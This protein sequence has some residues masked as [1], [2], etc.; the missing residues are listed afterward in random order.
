M[1]S[2]FLLPLSIA[3]GGPAPA[4]SAASD[5]GATVVGERMRGERVLDL[6]VRSPVLPDV[7]HVRLLLP[8][9]WRRGSA[10]TWPVLWLLHGMRGD[11]TSWSE[12]SDVELLTA[13][14]DV[15]VVMPDG[16]GCG[17]YTDWWN[18]GAG[19]PPSWETF[20][21]TELRQIL[22]RGYGAGTSRAVAGVGAGGLGALGYA[23]R[24]RGL[25]R[26]AASFSAPLHILHDDPDGLDVSDLVQL[27][28]A[29]GSR[30]ADWTD[31]W[32]DPREQRIVWRQH[33][34]YDLADRLSG[35]RLHVASGDGSP[36]PFDPRP[37][38]AP[39][40]LERL[41]RTLSGEFTGK[42]KKLGVPV[43]THFYRGTHSWAYWQREL[44]AALPLLLAEIT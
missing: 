17:L 35:V 32:G 10:R 31:V 37:S 16:G 26:A 42:L 3:P 2:G 18:Q 21:L 14:L 29:I 41:S 6:A 19:G 24:H 11:H 13:D 27:A 43:S 8:P 39:D 28:V 33:N 4:P 44:R 40:V 20:H 12:H 23:A 25:F 15:L 34:P 5:D 38:R 22:E 9:G 36:G 30:G 7:A 1:T